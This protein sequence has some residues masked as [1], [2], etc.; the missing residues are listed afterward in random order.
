MDS[1]SSLS[2]ASYTPDF[3]YQVG[4]MDQPFSGG[5]FSV[6][7]FSVDLFRILDGIPFPPKIGRRGWLDAMLV[8]E[9]IV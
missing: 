3:L 8:V 6:A 7:R 2:V 9:T 1:V 5:L 4:A